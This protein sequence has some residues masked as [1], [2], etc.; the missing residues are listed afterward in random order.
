MQQVRLAQPDAA[1][2]KQWV[3]ECAGALGD[4]FAHGVGQ[5]VVAADD[6]V[7]KG[8]ARVDLH[9]HRHGIE[10]RR[11]AVVVAGLPVTA[12]CAGLMIERRRSLRQRARVRQRRA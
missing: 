9:C 2:D 11:S 12:F 10:A 3:V 7:I 4:R 6:K 8:V 5:L 1:I